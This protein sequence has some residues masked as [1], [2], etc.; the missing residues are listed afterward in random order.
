MKGHGAFSWNGSH[1]IVTG[2]SCGIGA[3]VAAAVRARGARVSIIARGGTRLRDTGERIDASWAV[4]DVADATGLSTAISTLENDNGPCDVLVSNAGLALPGILLDTPCDE[5]DHQMGINYG[6]SVNAVRC[7]LPG[8]IERGGGKL[9]LV[10]S[11]A[12][13]LGVVGMSGY[14]STKA[15]IRQFALCLRY[16]LDGTGV[17]VSVVYPPDTDT[18]GF[19]AENLRKPP[20]TAAISATIPPMSADHV[21]AAIVR[22]VERGRPHIGVDPTTR[23]M[24]WWAGVPEG[25]AAP[26]LRR[27]IRKARTA[28]KTC[29]EQ[30]V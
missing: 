20:E 15:A 3:A 24:L 27:T 12:A 17:T 16:E 9:V 19:A 30:E 26:F 4:A 13:L 6:G 5:V 7:V 14:A 23:F 22:G 28:A 8:M 10:S 21:A 25:M 18:P 29:R 1:V 2:G 11:T